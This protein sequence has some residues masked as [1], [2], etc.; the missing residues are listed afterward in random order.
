MPLLLYGVI[1]VGEAFAAYCPRLRSFERHQQNSCRP[2]VRQSLGVQFEEGDSDGIG[3]LPEHYPDAHADSH[4]PM[5]T[6]HDVAEH[7]HALFQLHQGHHVGYFF[8]EARGATLKGDCLGPYGLL[9]AELDPTDFQVPAVGA[10]APRVELV[11]AAGVTPLDQKLATHC[12]IPIGLGLSD[13]GRQEFLLLGFHACPFLNAPA[14]VSRGP[15]PL[16]LRYDGSP[17]HR[18][19]R[20]RGLCG[21]PSPAGVCPRTRDGADGSPQSAGRYPAYQG[22]LMRGLLHRY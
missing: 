20:D 17:E 10:E 14:V 22:D 19:C 8:T 12:R 11:M 6:P 2:C 5:V 21:S 3:G 4:L 13:D 1:Q 7:T 18:R 16:C 9:A 15:K